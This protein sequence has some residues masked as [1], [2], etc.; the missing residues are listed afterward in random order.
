[1]RHVKGPA[2]HMTDWLIIS[3]GVFLCFWS[4]CVLGFSAKL[5]R[6]HVRRLQEEE[7]IPDVPMLL[8]EALYFVVWFA[9]FLIGCA[10]ITWGWIR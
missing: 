1:M 10:L 7:G 8:S 9:V 4:L 6:E 5:R 2:T 3:G